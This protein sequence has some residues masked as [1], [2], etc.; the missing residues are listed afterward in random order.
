MAR[1]KSSKRYPVQRTITL[2]QVAPAAPN[3]LLDCGNVMSKVNHRLYRQSRYYETKVDIT[4]DSPE[5]TTVNVYALADTWWTQKSLQL[6]K[7]AW[8]MSN[9]EEKEM[10]AGKIARWNDFRVESGLTGAGFLNPVQFQNT[11]AQTVFTAGEFDNAEV[12]DQAGVTRTFTW[13]TTPGASEYSIMGE[14]D[15]QA[16]TSS[17][18]EIPGTGPY[19]GLLPNLDTGAADALQDNGNEPPYNAA[20]Y[21]SGLWVKVAT[22]N[23]SA[24]RQRLSTGFFSAPCGF[25][26]LQGIGTINNA[27]IQVEMKR[28]DYKGVHAPSMLE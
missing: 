7:S 3:A 25:V 4:A 11:L 28:G 2:Q 16:G 12:V 26:F 24:G 1:R 19:T 10:L 18:P 14:Y 8:D 17:D 22:L 27:D 6:A 20:G 13:S 23:I 21:G 5:G 9:A 15:N